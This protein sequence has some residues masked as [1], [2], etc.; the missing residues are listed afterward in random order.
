MNI[1]RVD[2]AGS[3]VSDYIEKVRLLNAGETKRYY[4]I[5]YGCQMNVHDSEHLAGLLLQMGYISCDNK[6]DADFILF[7]TCCVRENAELRVYGNVG[8]LRELKE[9]HP[10]L[11]IAICGCMMQQQAVVESIKKRFEF[12]DIIFG[13]HN[14]QALPGLLY[15]ALTENGRCMEAHDDEYSI[16]EGAPIKRDSSFSAWITVMY[17]CNNFCSYC[18]V[19]YVRGRERSR[20]SADILTEAKQLAGQGCKEI[21]LLGQNVNSYGKDCG[22]ISFA[23]LLR[24]LNDIDGIERIG[25]MTS[26]PKD[27]SDELISAIADCKKVS[28]QLHLPVQSG[29]DRILKLMN[30]RY[31]HDEYLHLADKIKTAV[32]DIALSTDIIVG[33]PTETEEDFMQTVQLY[34]QVRFASAFMFAYSRRAGTPAADMKEQVPQEVKK[35]RLSRLIELQT[36]CTTEF[37]KRYIGNIYPV[38]AESV[39]KRSSRV[40]SG[41]T[42]CGRMVSFE[43]DSSVIG[44]IVN[45]KITQL[46]ANTL[47]GVLVQ[48]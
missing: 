6:E 43:A 10:G 29:S 23:E 16:M 5:T 8:A 41:R 46:K 9:R 28:R 24:R 40:I 17:G 48:Q 45:V 7:N 13:S 26:H 15:R 37:H 2:F 39:S 47:Y 19:P 34:N 22:E 4:I 38:L 20:R 18:I 1:R 42:H 11:K 36:R 21:T 27:C 44:R 3:V 35:D 12:V 31:T 32:P 33:F 30:R 14:A 25:F